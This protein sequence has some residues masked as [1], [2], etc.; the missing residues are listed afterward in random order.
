MR[1]DGRVCARSRCERGLADHPDDRTRR[2]LTLIAKSLQCLANLSSFGVKEQYM[3]PMN[4]FMMARAS[5]QR[6]SASGWNPQYA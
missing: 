3:V 4:D 5:D 6:C 1:C 2:S